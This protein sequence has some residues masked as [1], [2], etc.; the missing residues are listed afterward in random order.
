MKVP[1]LISTKKSR[2]RS[3]CDIALTYIIKLISCETVYLV[4]N[5][6]IIIIIKLLCTKYT[7]LQLLL[8]ND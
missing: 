6:Y 8:Y 1:T 4:E 5:Y 7:V 2:Y 3:G